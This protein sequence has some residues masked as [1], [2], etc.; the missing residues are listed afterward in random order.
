MRFLSVSILF[1]LLSPAF[2][3]TILGWQ[4]NRNNDVKD[5]SDNNVGKFEASAIKNA[6]NSFVPPQIKFTSFEKCVPCPKTAQCVP[7]I[8]CPAHLKMSKQP[9]MCDLPGGT[10]THGLCCS[11]KQN[12]TTSDFFKNRKSSRASAISKNLMSDVINEAQMEFKIAMH[13]EKH[14]RKSSKEQPQPTARTFLI[15]PDFFHH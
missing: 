6:T 14:H 2:S 3:F 12:H 1:F 15:Q 11:T 10:G 7:A 4:R 8:Q 13:N 5:R 9:Q